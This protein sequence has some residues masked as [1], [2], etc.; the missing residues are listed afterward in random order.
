MQTNNTL[1][2]RLHLCKV[3]LGHS[4]NN[5]PNMGNKQSSTSYAKISQDIKTS[6]LSEFENVFSVKIEDKASQ[7]CIIKS[8]QLNT[9]STVTITGDGNSVSQSNEAKLS[10]KCQIEKMSNSDL[11]NMISQALETAIERN[12]SNDVMQTLKQ[13]ASNGF[14]SIGGN[15]Q[16][17][18]T[19]TYQ[20]Q[21]IKTEVKNVVRNE[22]NNTI[23]ETLMQTARGELNQKNKT[24]KVVIK[25][26][27]NAFKQANKVESILEL[28]AVKTSI[29]QI[30]N[31]MESKFK[32][33]EVVKASSTTKQEN[34]QKA[35]NKGLEAVFGA[36]SGMACLGPLA[37]VCCI[38]L[39][40]MVMS[41]R[42]GGNSGK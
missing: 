28:S 23:T 26:D 8:S 41:S 3:V 33:A 15:N 34:E 10:I 42:K 35:E 19:T 14:L 27:N 31:N 16:N 11:R 36:L 39:L 29:T 20:D 32:L 5:V 21:D 30:L 24:F 1:T 6:I 9:T 4:K 17:S 12:I 37:I 25:G 18:K 13:S 38:L 22:V 40:L 7:D 2:L